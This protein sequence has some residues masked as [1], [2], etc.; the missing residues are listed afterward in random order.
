MEAHQGL[1]VVVVQVEKKVERNIDFL[2]SYLEKV[3]LP[4]PCRV[5]GEERVHQEQ[6]CGMGGGVLLYGK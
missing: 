2:N 1:Q 3:L 4:Q 5:A 6:V